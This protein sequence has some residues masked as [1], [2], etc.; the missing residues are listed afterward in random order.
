VGGLALAPTVMADYTGGMELW[1][2]ADSIVANNGDPVSLWPDSSGNV[3]RDATQSGVQRPTYLTNQVGGQPALD[4]NNSLSQFMS[5]AD[6]AAWALGDFH[7]TAVLKIDT[8]SANWWTRSWLAQDEGPN[9]VNKWIWSY[10][11]GGP[12]SVFHI[13]GPGT[14]GPV[15][16]PSGTWTPTGFDYYLLELDKSGSTYTFY[17]NGVSQ[18]TATSAA[19]IPNVAAPLTIGTAEGGTFD[20]Q[21][22]EIRIYGDNL[23]E[24]QRGDAG[25]ALELKYGLNT[26]YEVPEPATLTALG[27]LSLLALRRTRAR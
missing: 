23:T 12:K 24:S 3:G 5:V 9:P 27:A 10:D 21:I 8:A 19:V 4:F 20:G 14:G 13:N 2:K 22:A 16:E 17:L 1:L 15:L 6:N 25:G 18:G 26:T 7:M 11:L